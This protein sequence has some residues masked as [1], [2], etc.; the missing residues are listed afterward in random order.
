M[1]L[2]RRLNFFFESVSTADLSS[3]LNF[4]NL[5]GSYTFLNEHTLAQNAR[6]ENFEKVTHIG[7]SRVFFPKNERSEIEF[8]YKYNSTHTLHLKLND[9]HKQQQHRRNTCLSNGE[10]DDDTDDVVVAFLELDGRVRSVVQIF[11]TVYTEKCREYQYEN[12]WKC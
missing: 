5:P 1:F 12:V 11:R 10:N 6:N 7:F 9:K 4:L 3:F 2:R 8:R